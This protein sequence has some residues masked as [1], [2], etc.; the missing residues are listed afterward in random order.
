MP[1]ETR[2]DL[3]IRPTRVVPWKKGNHCRGLASPQSRCWRKSFH[4]FRETTRFRRRKSL[5]FFASQNR[6]C[7]GGVCATT[8]TTDRRTRRVVTSPLLPHGHLAGAK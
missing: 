1:G 3:E 5:A 7:V 6:V 2:T 8:D 4:A